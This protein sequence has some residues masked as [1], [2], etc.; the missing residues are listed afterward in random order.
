MTKLESLERR[1]EILKLLQDKELRTS[2]IATHFNVDERT[3]R[4]DISAL[5]EGMNVFGVKI[6]IESKHYDGNPKHYYKSTVHPI[7]MALNLSELFAL[8]KLLEDARKQ[9]TGEV[10]THIFN[11]VYNQIT[12]YAEKM[13]ADKLKD[14]YEKS[15]VKNT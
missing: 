13:I 4:K 10:Y 1:L 14:K 9:C 11:I 2:E 8:L 7:M 6:K 3:I 15:D 5:R 12:D